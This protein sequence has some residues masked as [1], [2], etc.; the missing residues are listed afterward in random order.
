MTK[1]SIA[2][3][4]A[5]AYVKGLGLFEEPERISGRF[6]LNAFNMNRRRVRVIIST[7]VY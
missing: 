6:D 2:L 5:I 1:V 7:T 3:D 4:L